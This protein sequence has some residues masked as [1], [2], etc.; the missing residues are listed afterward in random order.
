MTPFLVVL[1]TERNP[2]SC[3]LTNFD[4][5]GGLGIEAKKRLF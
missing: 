3:L 2:L 1:K 5:E 4:E